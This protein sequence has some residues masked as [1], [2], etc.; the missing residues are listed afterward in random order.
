MP[1]SAVLK[2]IS[3]LNRQAEYL[4]FLCDNINETCK[5][6][7]QEEKLQLYQQIR[8]YRRPSEQL[9]LLANTSSALSFSPL[10]ICK[11]LFQNMNSEDPKTTTRYLDVL[12]LLKKT[13]S[14]M[15]TTE[16]N[17][18]SVILAGRYKDT[19]LP[20]LLECPP[21]EEI[22]LPST[23]SQF[24]KLYKQFEH[25]G[26]LRNGELIDLKHTLKE[27]MPLFVKMIEKPDLQ[28]SK[29]F[30]QGLKNEQLAILC[31]SQR[32]YEQPFRLI[33]RYTS[34]LSQNDRPEF[35]ESLKFLAAS[36]IPVDVMIKLVD[37]PDLCKA[38]ELG[39]LDEKAIT[40][41]IDE[42]PTS[43]ERRI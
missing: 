43:A 6:A 24:T 17:I 9:L 40:L 23:T 26:E 13:G 20:L 8:Q 33:T 10:D 39:I 27:H 42:A 25:C 22:F 14:Q 19:S 2:A 35:S 31:L 28:G 34:F 29:L 4:S 16:Q 7:S 1:F 12:Q 11:D 36:P 15:T 30:A 32:L 5:R 21:S 41:Q 3:R 38:Y 37:R 18:L